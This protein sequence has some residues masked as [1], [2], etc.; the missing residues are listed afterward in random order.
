MLTFSRPTILALFL[1]ILF[2]VIVKKDKVVAGLLL[3]VLVISPF[4]AP[5]GLKDWARL[6]N[7]NPIIFMCNHDRISIYR[8]SLNMI[9]HH[10]VLG[11]GVNTF[12]KN[13]LKYKLPEPENAQTA[14]NMYAHNTFLQMAGEIGLLGLL[15]FLWLLFNLFKRGARIYRSLSDR[16]YKIISLSLSVCLF[17]FLVNGLTETSLYY[18]RVA[19]IF[20][21][22]AGFS[23][24]LEKFIDADNTSES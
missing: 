10:P 8:N 23:L 7:Y 22:L 14:D 5:K 9:R 12:S 11:V 18:A 20:W 13:Y 21:Y 3:L 4:V 15:A 2:L 24:A 6:I 17:A 1:S 19:M 16:Y